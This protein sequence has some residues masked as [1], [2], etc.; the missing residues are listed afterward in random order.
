M[1]C[2]QVII[3]SHLLSQSVSTPG[4]GGST[5]DARGGK[6]I[7]KRTFGASLSPAIAITSSA[8]RRRLH[9]RPWV[10]NGVT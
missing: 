1:P 6:W 4:N 7:M 3:T 5:S 2:L 9:G 10:Q 8:R